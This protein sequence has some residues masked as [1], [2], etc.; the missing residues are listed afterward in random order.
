MNLTTT[1][2][3]FLKDIPSNISVDKTSQWR[4]HYFEGLSIDE[5]SSFIKSIKD[6]NIYLLIPLFT[7]SKSWSNTTL[8]VSESFL[9][10]NKSNS[11]LIVNFILDQWNSSGFSIRKETILTFSL[12]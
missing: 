5:M 1:K 10:N 4:V 12:K 2:I 8:N 7:N 6:D 11:V 9:V 3:S